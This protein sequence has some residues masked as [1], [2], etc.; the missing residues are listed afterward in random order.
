MTWRINMREDKGI[1]R[2]NQSIALDTYQMIIDSSLGKEMKPG[3]FVNIKVNGYT[4]RRPISIS[5]IEED[6][7]TIIY[8]VVGAGTKVLSQL[9]SKDV[10]DV[11]GPLGSSF[12]IHEEE[13]HILIVGGGV[14]IPPLYEVA[15]QYRKLGK[16]VCA[17]LGFND[18]ESIFYEEELKA[19]GCHVIVA[20][21][22][23]SYGVKGTVL[24]A[25]KEYGIMN[26]FLYSCG[27]MPMLKALE[28]KYQKGYTSFEARMACGIG[29]CMGCVCK[30][31]KDSEI[32]Y[33]ICKEGPVFPI[34]KVGL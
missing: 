32:Y 1:I 26:D 19:L 6:S 11:I 25:I 9:K 30:D 33:R 10:L 29:A 21:M 7:Y 3:Q 4:L 18:K 16:D 14:G 17:V 28:E 2:S 5:S 24:D 13:D 8:K 20:T 22:D 23:G 31:K 15:K 34:G 27:P 12:P